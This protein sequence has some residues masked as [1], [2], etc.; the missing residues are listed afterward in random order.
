[1]RVADG[2][3][4][5]LQ[6]LEQVHLTADP[7]AAI[8]VLVAGEILDDRLHR[9]AVLVRGIGKGDMPAGGEM[10]IGPRAAVAHETIEVRMSDVALELPQLESTRPGR[11]GYISAFE[12]TRRM[13][14]QGEPETRRLGP[15]GHVVPE[16][17]V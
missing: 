6:V 13:H 5:H 17:I 4:G 10:A 2:V 11:L 3:V 1:M 15:R 8:A 14:R 12:C 16:N 7:H 9:R